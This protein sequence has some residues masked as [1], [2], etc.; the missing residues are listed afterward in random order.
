MGPGLLPP[1]CKAHGPWWSLSPH[2]VGRP[3]FMESRRSLLRKLKHLQVKK[4]VRASSVYLL[5]AQAVKN[6]LILYY[7]LTLEI[8]VYISMSTNFV[9]I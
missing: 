3:H 6:I 4:V 8:I 2:R 7:L 5:Q 9:T 1:W